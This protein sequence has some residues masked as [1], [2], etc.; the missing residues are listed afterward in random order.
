MIECICALVPSI[1]TATHV[2]LA[3]HAAE[4]KKPTGTGLLAARCLRNAR[5]VVVDDAPP[6]ALELGAPAVVLADVEGA[7]D[8]RDVVDVVGGRVRTLVVPDGTWRQARR[9]RRRIPGVDTLP[10][11]KLPPGAPTE[12]ALRSDAHDGGLATLEAIA[13]ALAILEDDAA[14]ESAMMAP[15][16]ALVQRTLAARGVRVGHG[17]RVDQNA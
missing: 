17:A 16:R 2:V 8:V 6:A 15:F 13:R 1:D 11:V 9:I 5:V 10:C 7:I 3:I 4:A 12:Y 14:I